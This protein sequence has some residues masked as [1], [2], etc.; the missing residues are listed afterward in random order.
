MF[1]KLA[2]VWA[3]FAV[4]PCLIGNKCLASPDS[5]PSLGVDA[6]GSLLP[7]STDETITVGTVTGGAPETDKSSLLD[8]IGNY[9]LFRKSFLT[10][11]DAS[12]P[13][14]FSWTK[15]KG[16]SSFYELDFALGLNPQGFP[17]L[18][19]GYSTRD[20]DVNWKIQPTFEAHTST[21]TKAEQDSL[22]GRL[23]VS[24]Y[25]QPN[26]EDAFISQHKVAI[27]MVYETDRHQE[28]AT[29]GGDLYY[30]PTIPAL[31]A[32]IEQSSGDLTFRWRPFVGV[33]GGHILE[34][35]NGAL[36]PSKSEFFR[37]VFKLHADLWIGK[38]FV[39][40]ADYSMRTEL[41][42]RNETHPY[43]EV[44]PTLFLDK[45][46]HFSVG[47]SYKRGKTTPDFSDINSI[48]AWVG[49]LF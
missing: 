1:R 37:F 39:L 47:L 23:P 22:S 46:R 2:A 26:R 45:D 28:T 21:K 11:D 34:N 20:W 19:N 32:G 10:S 5:P 16:E 14:K 31:A 13:A 42:G 38:Q 49:L 18:H 25:F 44:S 17:F 35:D 48:N 4:T 36:D 33:E 24:L 6:N 9:F 8:D 15:S 30:T 41:I 40:A 27:S 12:E 7:D 43:V 29:F 3:I